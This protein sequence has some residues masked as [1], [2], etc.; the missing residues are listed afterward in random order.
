MASDA[1]NLAAIRSN[2][3]TTLADLTTNPKPNYS[4]NGQSVSWQSLYD[5]LWNQLSKVNEQMAAV[6][7]P[8]EHASTGET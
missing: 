8:F 1:E 3:L 7:G 4:I 2:L 6:G 5:S